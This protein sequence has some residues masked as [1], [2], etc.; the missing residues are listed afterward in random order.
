MRVG[1]RWWQFAV[2]VAARLTPEERALV[3]ATLIPTELR[4][5]NVHAPDAGFA[6]R[7]RQG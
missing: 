3:A 7:L 1:Y 6:G 5:F 4:L 2:A